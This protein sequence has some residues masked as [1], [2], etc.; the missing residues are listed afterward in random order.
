MF[1]ITS[2]I[3]HLLTLPFVLRCYI[4]DEFGKQIG[5]SYL[6]TQS[7]L[8]NAKF[9]VLANGEGADWSTRKYFRMAV[10][11]PYQVQISEEYFSIP[12]GSMCITLS[13]AYQV[14]GG[15]QVFCCDLKWE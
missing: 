3:Q 2:A 7:W 11:T 15:T 9:A 12:D 13:V 6:P 5:T 8:G 14:D 1:A 4:L 10:A